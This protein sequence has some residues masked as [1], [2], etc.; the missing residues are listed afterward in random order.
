[1]KE[2]DNISNVLVVALFGSLFHNRITMTNCVECMGKI[3]VAYRKTV[4]KYK[5]TG[6]FEEM[7]WRILLNNI[8]GKCSVKMWNDTNREQH[9]SKEIIGRTKLL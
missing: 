2:C 3:R 6:Y 9:F 8:L 1:M 4:G 7:L 5:Q